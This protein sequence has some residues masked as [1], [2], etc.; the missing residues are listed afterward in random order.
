MRDKDILQEVILEIGAQMIKLAGKGESIEE[1]KQKIMD[2]IDS[3]EAYIKFLELIE[4]QGG[5]VSYINDVSKF[6]NAKF[7]HPIFV[8]TS[9]YVKSIDALKIGKIS[10]ALGAGR[11]KKEDDIDSQ[12]GLI[13]NKKVGNKIEAGEIIGII[14]ANDEEKLNNAVE[15]F[16]D[17]IEI[18]EEYVER[19]A[20][21]LG[22]ME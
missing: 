10:C 1:N 13:I 16:E 11:V 12:V 3:G 21:I 8:N 2:V 18:C 5:D 6:E 14:H 19:E 20:V 4:A 7:V 22:I 15:D 17:A 9:G